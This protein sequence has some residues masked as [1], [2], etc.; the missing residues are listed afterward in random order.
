MH[1]NYIRSSV[2]LKYY[3]GVGDF[4]GRYHLKLEKFRTMLCGMLVYIVRV[5]NDNGRWH[6]VGYFGRIVTS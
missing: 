5:K 4:R 2:H 3:V 6:C 1:D